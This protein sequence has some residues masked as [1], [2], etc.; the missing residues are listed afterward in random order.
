M[1]VGLSWIHYCFNIAIHCCE[2]NVKQT[3]QKCWDFSESSFECHL[4]RLDFVI[5]ISKGIKNYKQLKCGIFTTL[6]KPNATF[7]TCAF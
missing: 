4:G 3:S 7:T 2:I 6:I 5:T 1:L